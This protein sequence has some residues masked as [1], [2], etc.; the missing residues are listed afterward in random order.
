MGSILIR[1][2]PHTYVLT[3]PRPEERVLVFIHGWLLS[4]AYWQPLLE[5]LQD[6]CQCLTYD[7]RGFGYSISAPFPEASSYSPIAYAEDLETLLQA[8]NIHKAWLIGHSLGGMIALRCA[9][10]YPDRIGGVICINAGGGIYLKEEFEQFRALGQQ[11]LRFRPDWLAQ[12]PG[13]DWVFS[14]LSV[15]QPLDRRWGRQR[16]LDFLRANPTA[17][18][19]ALLESTTEQEVHQLPQLVSQLSQPAYFIGGD[20]DSIMEPQYVR[21]L[22]SF[23]PLFQNC[24]ANWLELSDCGHFAML[25]HTNLVADYVKT[26]LQ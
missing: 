18:L 5:V 21:H 10:L 15:R 25:E 24:G 22:A 9:S 16:C 19:G 20:G 1:G 26:C 8:L 12:I 2:I 14:R 7:L 13:I 6:Q 17:A 23:H 4:Q 11:L 3:P